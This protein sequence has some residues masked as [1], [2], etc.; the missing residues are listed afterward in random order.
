M[1]LRTA[2]SALA[3]LSML[4]LPSSVTAQNMQVD[5]TN[6]DS[7]HNAA[8]TIA[9]NMMSY[10]NGNQSGQA[11]GMFPGSGT[12]TGYYWWEGAEVFAAL[13]KY[14]YYFGDSCMSPGEPQDIQIT[15]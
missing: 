4:C 8:S 1:Q 5:F 2:F 11:P 9:F 12:P 6:M 7:L 14:W 10:Y 3:G 15:G 13:M